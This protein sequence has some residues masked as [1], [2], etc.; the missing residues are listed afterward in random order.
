MEFT[1]EYLES[2]S[3][4][5]EHLCRLGDYQFQISLGES[6]EFALP[7]WTTSDGVCHAL[8]EVPKTDFGDLYV[9]LVS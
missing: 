2:T 3:R 7:D 8:A 4:C 6:M 9:R 1:P 5:I